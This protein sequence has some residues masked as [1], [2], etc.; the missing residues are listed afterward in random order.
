MIRS[1]MFWGV[2]ALNRE[3]DDWKAR[4]LASVPDHTTYSIRSQTLPPASLLLPPSC[5]AV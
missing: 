4:L 3:L 1:W 2:K 5:Q